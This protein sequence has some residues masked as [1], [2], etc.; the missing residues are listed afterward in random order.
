MFLALA[1][2][3]DTVLDQTLVT[4]ASVALV[5]ASILWIVL[6]R[7]ILRNLRKRAHVPTASVKAPG[8]DIWKEPPDDAAG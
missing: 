1:R 5:A 6:S 2:N 7:L 4:A 8:R 3:G